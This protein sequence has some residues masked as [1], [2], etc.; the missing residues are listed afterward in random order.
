MMMMLWC[1]ASCFVHVLLHHHHVVFQWDP[2][3]EQLFQ[4]TYQLLLAQH[5]CS[6]GV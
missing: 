2:G 1:D 4:I 5:A 3:A 6:F